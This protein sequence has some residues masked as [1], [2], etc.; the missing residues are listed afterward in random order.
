MSR[1]VPWFLRPEEPCIPLQSCWLLTHLPTPN[2]T[3]ASVKSKI[4]GAAK[5]KILLV[6]N[7]K[8]NQVAFAKFGGIDDLD[9]IVTDKDTPAKFLDKVDKKGVKVLAV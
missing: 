1:P 6:D 2:M 4:I 7:T 8:V 5:Y 3:E 9:C